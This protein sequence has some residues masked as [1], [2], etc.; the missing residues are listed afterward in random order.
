VQLIRE[1]P[2]R[3]ARSSRSS[4]QFNQESKAMHRAQFEA[5]RK[6]TTTPSGRIAYLEQ[7]SVPAANLHPGRYR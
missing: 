2:I 3:D 6:F 7:D 1:L 5:I 4:G